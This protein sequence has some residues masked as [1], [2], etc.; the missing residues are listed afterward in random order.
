MTSR[1][2]AVGSHVGILHANADVASAS[3]VSV[4]LKST[5]RDAF[6]SS[7]A[8]DEEFTAKSIV[9]FNTRERRSI[10]SRSVNAACDA[11]VR[12]SFATQRRKSTCRVRAQNSVS[13][14]VASSRSNTRNSTLQDPSLLLK[15]ESAASAFARS[16]AS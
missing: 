3:C 2:T 4:L 8:N 6:D 13:T 11:C 16:L 9:S 5:A 7:C 14:A 12:S 10:Q 15:L 1:T